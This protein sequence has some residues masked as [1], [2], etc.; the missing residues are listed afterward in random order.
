MDGDRQ[1]RYVEMSYFQRKLYSLTIRQNFLNT[2][3]GRRG[4][5]SDFVAAGYE[6]YIVDEPFRARSPWET[7]RGS[8]ALVSY[9]AEHLQQYFTATSKYNLWPEAAL[10]TQWPGAGVMGDAVFDQFYAACI[11][12][13]PNSS[14]EQAAAQA[15]GVALLDRIARPAV[16]VGHSQGGPL[17]LLLADQRPELA[18]ALILLEPAGPP[19]REVVFSNETKRDWGVSEIAMTYDPPVT[20]P[21]K[22]LVKAVR[23]YDNPLRRECIV[24]ADSPPPRRLKNVSGK[25][26]LVVTAESSYHHMYDHC[27]VDF[28][29]QAGCQKLEHVYLEDIGIIG[30]GHMMFMEKN[31]HEIQKFLQKWIESVQ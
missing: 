29:R 21:A 27:T 30:N 4:W 7:G 26:V 24:Q 8:R 28:L 14:F 2:P 12:F 1:V 31:S 19:F 11:Q 3:D 13:M 23:T 20:D 6:V 5:A 25:N 10:H 17:P 18:A 16:I 15:A 22:E 9:S